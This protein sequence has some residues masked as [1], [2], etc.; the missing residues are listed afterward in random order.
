ME[1]P[2]DFNILHH[3]V[4]DR[5][6]LFDR[7][8][9]NLPLHRA[10]RAYQEEILLGKASSSRRRALST[11][12]FDF[13]DRHF[14]LLLFLLACTSKMDGLPMDFT[15]VRSPEGTDVSHLTR[16]SLASEPGAT[17]KHDFLLL[18]I[19][20]AS[21]HVFALPKSRNDRA[22]SGQPRIRRE[23]YGEGLQPLCKKE[24]K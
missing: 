1:E 18:N 9:D 5:Q 23:V 6:M 21:L 17:R 20:V 3:E 24:R 7:A 2:T 19:S 8:G 13:A 15:H 22:E 12:P 11:P 10:F 14:F 4:W 16:L